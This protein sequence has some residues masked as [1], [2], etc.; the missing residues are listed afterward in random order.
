MIIYKLKL[1]IYLIMKQNR[2]ILPMNL[3]QLICQ[4][5]LV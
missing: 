2:Y 3:R 4:D 1:L 5:T